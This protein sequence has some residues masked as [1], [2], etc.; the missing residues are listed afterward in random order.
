MKGL[1]LS[2]AAGLTLAGCGWHYAL[3]VTSPEP[4]HPTTV[5]FPQVVRTERISLRNGAQFVSPTRLA[6]VTTGSSSCPSVPDELV[7]VSPH[8]LRIHLT[9]GS[10]GPDHGE[11]VAHPPPNGIC[12]ADLGTTPMLVAIDPALIDVHRPLTVR[13]FYRD[14]KT[15]LVRIA[16]PLT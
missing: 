3:P 16:A 4:R 7:Y 11:F 9:T 14:S 15:P 2:V 5:H 12:T 6:I 1:A 10:Y 8:V 13:L